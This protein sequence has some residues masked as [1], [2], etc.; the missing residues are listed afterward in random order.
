MFGCTL[1]GSTLGTHERGPGLGGGAAK[2]SSSP[3]DA[4]YTAP[5]G[6]IAGGD[7]PPPC[8]SNRPA[9]ASEAASSV[10][11]A[12]AVEMKT[13]VQDAAAGTMV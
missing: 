1:R 3:E 10:M 12:E 8:Q 2:I 4:A 6:A 7:T 9:G 5:L 13:W 11:S